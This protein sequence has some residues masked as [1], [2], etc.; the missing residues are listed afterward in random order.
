M[1]HLDFVDLKK[2]KVKK[3]I[4]L[5]PLENFMGFGLSFSVSSYIYTFFS[6]MNFNSHML[7]LSAK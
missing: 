2:K 6:L 4:D 3:L 5:N 7:N 1:L